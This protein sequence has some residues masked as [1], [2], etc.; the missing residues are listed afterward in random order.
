MNYLLCVEL[1]IICGGILAF[2]LVRNSYEAMYQLL[3]ADRDEA[4]TEVQ[5]LRAALFPQ[6]AKLPRA[7]PKRAQAAATPPGHSPQPPALFSSRI[8]W[9]QRFKMLSAQHNT[10]QKGRDAMAGAIAKSQEAVNG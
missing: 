9:R 7:E 8:P 6:L 3:I 4:R 2:V 10:K 5:T 1:A